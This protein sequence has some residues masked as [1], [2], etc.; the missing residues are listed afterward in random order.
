MPRP[1]PP[2]GQRRRAVPL[3]LT[4]E[5]E[6]PARE[7]ADAEHGGNLSEAIRRII[8]EWAGAQSPAGRLS[9]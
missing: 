2:G 7:L 8:T 9:R 4:A 3:R 1:L 5:E 6:R